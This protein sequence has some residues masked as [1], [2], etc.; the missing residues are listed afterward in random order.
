M[1]RNLVSTLLHSAAFGEPPAAPAAER[2]DLA[3]GDAH[4]PG[5]R[6]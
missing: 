1:G 6:A 5:A 3:A 2:P 4:S